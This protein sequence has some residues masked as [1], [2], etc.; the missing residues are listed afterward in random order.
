MD[1][2]T[3]LDQLSE[4]LLKTSNNTIITPQYVYLADELEKMLSLF[5]AFPEN[6]IQVLFALKANNHIPLVKKL[7]NCVR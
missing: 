5:S 3:S 6:D 7:I 2:I 4:V 1:K